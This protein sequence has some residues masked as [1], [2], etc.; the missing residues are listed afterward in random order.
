MT[1]NL[2]FRRQRVIRNLICM[3]HWSS[4]SRKCHQTT[5]PLF[6]TNPS[7]LN[8]LT[9]TTWRRKLNSASTVHRKVVSPVAFPLPFKIH[10]LKLKIEITP[11][12]NPYNFNVLTVHEI[13]IFCKTAMEFAFT[14]YLAYLKVKWS[15]FNVL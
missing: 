14:G 8:D 11:N 15:F 9:C 13:V 7:D 6:T 3:D 2:F 5:Y 4:N 1:I 10:K 12:E